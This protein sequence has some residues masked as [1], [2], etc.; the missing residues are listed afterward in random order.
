MTPFV[1]FIS[2][3]RSEHVPDLYT[4]HV[5]FH[6][7]LQKTLTFYIVYIDLRLTYTQVHMVLGGSV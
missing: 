7:G 5:T 3:I 1:E 6:Q 2:E 4:H